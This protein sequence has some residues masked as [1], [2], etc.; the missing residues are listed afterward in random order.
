VAVP[1][2]S[3]A[4]PLHSSDLLLSAH[5]VLEAVIASAESEVIDRSDYTRFYRNWFLDESPTVDNLA[6]RDV[7][8]LRGGAYGAST[9]VSAEV[10]IR[11]LIGRRVI[12][13]A[14]W[15]DG[16]ARYI[17]PLDQCVLFSDAN[18]WV[19]LK[20]GTTISS[21]ELL[22]N[23]ENTNPPA[24]TRRAVVVAEGRVR[25]VHERSKTRRVEG[26]RAGR[27]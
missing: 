3:I 25:A 27:P 16:L 21:A 5:I 19:R 22:A 6:L 26:R 20:D 1:V 18:I 15:V 9:V 8:V 24:L 13:C 2:C 10:P 7:K 23:V 11:H 4:Q 17:V 12:L 14:Y